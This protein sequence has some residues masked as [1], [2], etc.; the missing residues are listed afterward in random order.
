MCSALGDALAFGVRHIRLAGPVLEKSLRVEHDVAIFEGHDPFELGELLPLVSEFWFSSTHSVIGRVLERPFPSR[1]LLLPYP[2]PKHAPLY[3]EIFRCR[4]DFNAGT[5][6]WHFDAALL[7]EKCPNANP[8]T[9]RMCGDFC[10]RMLQ[11]FNDD[12]P[13]LIRTVRS[14]CLNSTGGFPSLIE[15]AARINVSPRTLHRRLAESGL[16]YQAILDDV[17]RRLAEEYLR[18][19]ALSIEE[20]AARTG[21]SEASNFRKA[22]KKWTRELPADYRRRKSPWAN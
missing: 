1:R 21:F 17:R 16:S 3:S 12:E 11:S 9:A 4:V 14:A 2:A 18:N 22:F 13:E 15:V 7:K 8:I 20:I 6:Q 5:M 19:T 10:H